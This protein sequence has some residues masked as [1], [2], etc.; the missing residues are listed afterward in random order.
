MSDHA[1]EILCMA[2]LAVGIGLGV[3]LAF[4]GWAKFLETCAR[5]RD[6]G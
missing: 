1:W 4:T 5:I 3:Y 2:P 6:G